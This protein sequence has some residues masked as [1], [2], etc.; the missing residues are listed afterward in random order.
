MVPLGSASFGHQRIYPIFDPMDVLGHL[1]VDPVLSF[2]STAFPPAHNASDKIGVTVEGD[3]RATAVTLAGVLGSGVVTSAEHTL[4]DSELSRV[5]AVLP[6]HVGQGQALEDGGCL[7]TLTK[8]AETT[9]QPNWL[10]HQQL[11][12]KCET[13]S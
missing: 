10:P 13:P 8:A 6:V 7:L 9:D 2:P 12:G 4:R 11:G 3:M 5:Q 1:G